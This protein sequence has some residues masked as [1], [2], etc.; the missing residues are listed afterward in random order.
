[1]A[2]PAKKVLVIRPGECP[3]CK[4]DCIDEGDTE[5][6]ECECLLIWPSSQEENNSP[7]ELERC[8]I[9]NTARGRTK[10]GKLRNKCKP[11]GHD[12]IGSGKLECVYIFLLL[13]L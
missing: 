10:R 2:S 3:G 11:C 4:E 13:H 7:Q 8:P 1:M 9:C 5:C 6:A 12:Y